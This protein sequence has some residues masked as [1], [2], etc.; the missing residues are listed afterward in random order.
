MVYNF[1][2]EARGIKAIE[3]ANVK[4]R[5]MTYLECI[6]YNSLHLFILQVVSK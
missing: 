2:L 4:R 5:D 1:I 6:N 3:L